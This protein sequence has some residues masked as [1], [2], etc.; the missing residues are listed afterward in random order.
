MDNVEKS[1]IV[2]LY[3]SILQCICKKELSHKDNSFLSFKLVACNELKS[4]NHLL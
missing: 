2:A 1:Q 3:K 4:L